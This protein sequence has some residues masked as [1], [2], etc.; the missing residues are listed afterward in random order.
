[1]SRE[2][3]LHVMQVRRRLHEQFLCEVCSDVKTGRLCPECEQRSFDLE[4]R[5]AAWE[6]GRL[7]A[8]RAAGQVV[9][10][11]QPRY[12][13]LRTRIETACVA[14]VLVLVLVGAVMGLHLAGVGLMHLVDRWVR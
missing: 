3:E 1:M 8:R 5:R 12:M 13:D 9:E 6:S 2:A 7:A 10:W 4:A 14:I 11:P